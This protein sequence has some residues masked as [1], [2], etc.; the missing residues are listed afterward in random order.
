MSAD[1]KIRA[2][3]SL[4][5]SQQ[6][7]LRNACKHMDGLLK[8]IEAALDPTHTNSAFPKYIND[9][10][11]VQRKTI[12]EYLARF[13]TQ[14]LRILAGQAIQVEEPRIKASHAVHTS[15]TFIEIAIEELSPSRMRG[16]GPV[17]EAG[18]ADLNK[19]MQD[20]QSIVKGLHNYVLQS[21]LPSQ[22]QPAND[23]AAV[24]I[25]TTPRRR[26]RR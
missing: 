3:S 11:P 22:S 16:Y 9:I 14:L 23:S 13:R 10:T 8:E 21:N 15:L 4:S 25:S 7:N 5:D 26:D 12:E 1:P 6:R 17:S 18:A 2:I 19:V 24:R 20:L